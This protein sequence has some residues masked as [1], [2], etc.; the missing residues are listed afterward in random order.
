M[1]TVSVAQCIP[2]A[3]LRVWDRNDGSRVDAG[4]PIGYSRRGGRMTEEAGPARMRAWE[5]RVRDQPHPLAD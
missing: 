3:H 4:S 2:V 5:C 1:R